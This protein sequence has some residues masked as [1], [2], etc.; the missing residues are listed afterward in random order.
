MANLILSNLLTG[1]QEGSGHLA[2]TH[3][4]ISCQNKGYVFA[5][6]FLTSLTRPAQAVGTILFI[7][8][9]QE[10]WKEEP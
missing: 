4:A 2:P 7:S 5:Y 6:V 1:E 9:Q 3:V 10:R 8:L